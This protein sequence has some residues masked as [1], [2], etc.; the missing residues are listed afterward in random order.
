MF[1][2][3]FHEHCVSVLRLKPYNIQYLA[4]ISKKSIF[5]R[6]ILIGKGQHGKTKI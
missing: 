3:A 2:F 6:A 1:F 5:K 4:S